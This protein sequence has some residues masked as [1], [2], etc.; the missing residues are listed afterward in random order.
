MEPDLSTR[1][2]RPRSRELCVHGPG[3][4][5]TRLGRV[6]PGV[7]NEGRSC[8]HAQPACSGLLVSEPAGGCPC[9][10]SEEFCAEPGSVVLA[11]G[12]VSPRLLRWQLKAAGRAGCL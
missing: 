7:R 6:A 4:A 1:R 11:P 9:H 5:R 3:R 12:Y 8:N 2:I 10:L